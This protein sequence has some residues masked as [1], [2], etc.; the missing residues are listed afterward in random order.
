MCNKFIDIPNYEGLYQINCNGIIKSLINNKGCKRDKILKPKEDRKGYLRIGLTKNKKQK[1][2]LVHRLV[3]QTF[4]ANTNNYPVV[5][6]I[7]GNP[8]NNNINNLE[9]C[10]YSYNTKHA[11]KIGLK[12]GHSAVHIGSKNPKSKLTEEE[13][14]Q[15]LKLKN[16]NK[17]LKEV[18]EIYK[19]KITH[20][21]LENIWY[22]IS[23]KHIVECVE[24]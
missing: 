22:R 24:V 7:D 20:R 8:L 9:W 4:I 6:H 17:T 11:Y 3:A 12:K 23:W 5:N 1:F 13:V 18:Y 16:E 2:L 19:N 15:I 21:C 14:R 10:T